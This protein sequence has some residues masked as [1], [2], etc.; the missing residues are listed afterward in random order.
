MQDTCLSWRTVC[1]LFGVMHASVSLT[2]KVS[3]KAYKVN[4]VGLDFRLF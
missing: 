4:D 1:D 2:G 3:V